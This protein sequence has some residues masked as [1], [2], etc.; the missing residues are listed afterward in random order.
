LIIHGSI[1]TR[2]SANRQSC[3]WTCTLASQQPCQ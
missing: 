1:V 2:G 3:W